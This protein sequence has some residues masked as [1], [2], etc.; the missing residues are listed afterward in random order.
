MGWECSLENA[1]HPDSWHPKCCYRYPLKGKQIRVGWPNPGRS[2]SPSLCLPR[3]SS[4]LNFPSHSM[5]RSCS[6]STMDTVLEQWKVENDHLSGRNNF[7]K[8]L[9]PWWSS[10]NKICSECFHM[11]VIQSLFTNTGSMI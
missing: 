5:N 9:F 2:R 7:G 10:S 1:L 8:Y 4:A 3:C 6:C 11:E